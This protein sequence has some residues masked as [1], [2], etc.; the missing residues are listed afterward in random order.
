MKR[1][2]K[3][4]LKFL[5]LI[6]LVFFAIQFTL[7]SMIDNEY[8]CNNTLSKIFNGNLNTDIVILGNSR[9]EAHYNV[10]E[11]SNVTGFKAYNLGLSGTPLNILKVRWDA[12]KNRNVL[13]KVL[14]LDVDY[15]LLGSADK[16]VNKFQ[17]LP[18]VN[19]TE[20][21][22]VAK[23]VN[24][25]NS[26]EKYIPLY[27]YIGYSG[28]IVSQFKNLIYKEYINFDKGSIIRDKSW[29]ENEWRNFK[30]NRMSETVDNKQFSNIYK[31][32]VKELKSILD[33][34]QK[35]T[36]KV[37]MIWS[38]QYFEVHSF[39]SEQRKYVDSLLV[40]ISKSYNI[41]YTNFSNDSLVFDKSN[42]YNHSH[43]NKVGADQ[44]SKKVVNLITIK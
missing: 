6:Y 33:F 16:I 12:Y 20:Y 37:F 4:I 26:F 23:E 27:K 8:N 15:N 31:N 19:K 24:D 32:G 43:L 5:V 10:T 22:N 2:S 3:K 18:Y 39:K 9:A 38:P 13:P 30:Q 21:I 40:S 42:F 35:H 11:I 17:Y 28:Q 34:C 29:D 36:I 41:S 44:F 25:Y 7:D 1:F 14:I